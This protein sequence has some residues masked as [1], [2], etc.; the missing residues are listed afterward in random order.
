MSGRGDVVVEW[1][2]E[3]QSERRVTDLGSYERVRE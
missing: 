2:S 1:G 3:W